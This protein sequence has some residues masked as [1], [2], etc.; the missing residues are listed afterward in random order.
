MRRIWT[1]FLKE[2]AFSD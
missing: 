1:D 2:E